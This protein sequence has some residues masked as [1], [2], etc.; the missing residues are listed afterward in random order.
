MKLVVPPVPSGTPRLL[1]VTL[2]DVMYDATAVE[3]SDVSRIW[4]SY[5][6]VPEASV[7]PVQQNYP[8][9]RMKLHKMPLLDVKRGRPRKVSRPARTVT[10][11][12]PEDVIARLSAVDPDLGRAVVRL[13]MSQEP[14]A[15]SPLVEVAA[16]GTRAVILVPPLRRLSDLPGVEL[17]PVAD[18]R[19]LISLEDPMTEES[20]ELQI[21][22]A[23]EEATLTAQERT[24][25][26]TLAGVLR[27]ARAATRVTLRRILVLRALPVARRR[28]R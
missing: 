10:L 20:F 4:N 27:E 28:A 23:L 3:K 18:G 19:V 6:R 25:F 5:V 7:V 9:M 14:P 1:I 2:Y 22:D 26:E 15:T 16:F 12:L 17:V 13:S 24:V 11:T 21:R 8:R